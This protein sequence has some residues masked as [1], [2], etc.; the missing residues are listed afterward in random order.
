MQKIP[1]QNMRFVLLLI[2]EIQVSVNDL[3]MTSKQ[4]S[5]V[6]PSKIEKIK[7]DLDTLDRMTVIL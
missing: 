1:Q 5:A 7:R 3:R 6:D 2:E 4:W